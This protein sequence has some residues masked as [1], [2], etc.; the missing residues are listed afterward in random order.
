M[1]ISLAALS[2]SV[3]PGSTAGAADGPACTDRTL[4]VYSE[5]GSQGAIGSYTYEKPAQVY[6]PEWQNK[7]RSVSNSSDYWACLYQEPYYG[8]AVRTVAP[9]S[10]AN[11]SEGTPELDR[12]VGSH[13][14]AKTKAG[15]LTGFERCPEGDLCLFMG[16]HGRGRMTYLTAELNQYSAAWDDTVRS[17]AN[18]S[19]RTACF[20]PL[21]D[22]KGTWSAGGETHK[23]FVVLKAYSTNIPAPYAGTFTS[24]KLDATTSQC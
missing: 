16:E 22:F 21:R 4:C 3:L 9:R 2:F 20:Y 24:H 18:Y 8:G 14:L 12:K 17:V 6:G 19:D 7:I 15:C 13:K 23:T 11:L 10:S 5:P 1:G